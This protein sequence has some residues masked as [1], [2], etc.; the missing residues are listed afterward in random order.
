[1]INYT[2]II[3]ILDRHNQNI[4]GTFHRTSLLW[5]TV[6]ENRCNICSTYYLGLAVDLEGFSLRLRVEIAPRVPRVKKL[7]VEVGSG[8]VIGAAEKL[9]EKLTGNSLS[10]G[11]KFS[12]PGIN[13]AAEKISK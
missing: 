8:T 6:Q 10:S 2:L 9:A 11:P 12:K 3:F 7:K 1:M 4:V 13:G 5:S